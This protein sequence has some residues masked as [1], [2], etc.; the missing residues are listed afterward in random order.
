MTFCKKAK[1]WRQKTDQQLPR[2]GVRESSATKAFEGILGDDG[3]GL[4]SSSGY[5]TV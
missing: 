2:A 3:R 4:D 5:T 1:L